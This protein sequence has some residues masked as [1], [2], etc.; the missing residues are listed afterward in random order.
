M[1]VLVATKSALISIKRNKTRS[2]L[3][4]LGVIIG[5]S[6]VIL[7]TSLG[8]GLKVL[9]SD[10]FDALGTNQLMIVPGD[11]VN[12][13]GG[14][15]MAAAGLSISKFTIDDVQALK[16]IGDPVVSAAPVTE[17]SGEVRYKTEKITTFFMISS[18]DYIKIRDLDMTKGRFF[19][20][21][22]DSAGKR[23]VVIG[24]TLEEDL[25]GKV[26]GLGKEVAVNGINFEVIGIA[27]PKSVGGFGGPDFDSVV[28]IPYAIGK[29]N[30]RLQQHHVP[31]SQSRLCRQHEQSKNPRRQNSLQTT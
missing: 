23:V 14:I 18:P 28:Y 15:D 26:S 31:C 13:S 4:T 16:R 6:A 19:T 1:R 11:M 17:A 27:E 8:N 5:V 20:T 21:A 29:K 22:D 10:Q 12:E 30:S 7:L 2:L 3:T 9:I 24:P 25:F